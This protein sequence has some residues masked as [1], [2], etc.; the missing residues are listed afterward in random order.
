M[1]GISFGLDGGLG[2]LVQMEYIGTW[3]E[4]MENNCMQTIMYDIGE[5]VDTGFPTIRFSND[6]G[7]SYFYVEFSTLD[8][9]NEF[10][11]KINYA[12]SI[13][14]KKND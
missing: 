6:G 14:N 10:V 8:E 11:S 13:L 9:F 3:T 1:D 12:A 5:N 2:S 7:K 4:L